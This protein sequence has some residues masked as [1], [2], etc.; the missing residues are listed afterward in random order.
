MKIKTIETEKAFFDDFLGDIMSN[1]CN[2]KRN[3][4]Y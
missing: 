3:I 4:V 1:S 2:E